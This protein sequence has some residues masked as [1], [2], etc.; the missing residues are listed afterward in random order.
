MYANAIREDL[1]QKGCGHAAMVLDALALAGYESGDELSVS[2]AL[3]NFAAESI[4]MSAS[5]LR[6]GLYQ[7]RELNLIGLRIYNNKLRGAPVTIYR[8]SPM[9]LI[10]EKLGVVIKAFDKIT[11]AAVSRIRDYR[12]HLHRAFLSRRDGEYSRKWLGERLG[13][14]GRATFNYEQDFPEIEVTPRFAETQITWDNLDVLPREKSAGPVY[15]KICV[16][17]PLTEAEIAERY[18]AVNPVW[19]PVLRKTRLEERRFP[20][21]RAIAVKLL[22]EGHEIQLVRQQ[23]NYYRVK[24]EIEM[25]LESDTISSRPEGEWSGVRAEVKQPMPEETD[26]TLDSIIFHGL[27]RTP[28]EVWSVAYH[29]LELQLDRASFDTWLRQA[30]LV[31][32]EVETNTFVIEV[33]STYARDMLQHRLYRNVQRLLRDCSGTEPSARFVCDAEVTD[34][35]KPLGRFLSLLKKS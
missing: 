10:A 6:K 30:K 18:A 13:V 23:T 25:L 20:S 9:N 7:L 8:L 12:A 31:D 34:P 14:S 26:S 4:Q 1:F 21:L 28:N 29:Q 11:T 2:T 3:L 19:R 35:D 22:R 15:L 24:S 16:E 5:A 32:Y 17:V 33:H 27:I